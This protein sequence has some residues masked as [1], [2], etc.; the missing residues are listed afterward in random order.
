VIFSSRRVVVYVDNI[1]YFEF[2][3]VRIIR[4]IR[5]TLGEAGGRYWGNPDKSGWAFRAP[6]MLDI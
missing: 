1:F 6:V 3:A 5:P 4:W 2:R